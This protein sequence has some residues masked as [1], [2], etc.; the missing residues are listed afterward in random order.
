M[1]RRF[2]HRLFSGGLVALGITVCVLAVVAGAAS[3]ASGGTVSGKLYLTGGPVGPNSASLHGSVV[4]TNSSNSVKYRSSVSSSGYSLD[5]PAGRY[6]G[7][8]IT[9][10]GGTLIRC[11]SASGTSEVKKGHTAI[12]NFICA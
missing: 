3:G 2:S 12:V 4:F 11:T 1:T 6:V 5:L 8:A 9:T 10:T 7:R